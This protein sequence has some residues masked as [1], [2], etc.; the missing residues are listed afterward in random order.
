MTLKPW[1][2]RFKQGGEG[3]G[4]VYHPL[5]RHTPWTAT[6]QVDSSL[7]TP[8]HKH[9]QAGT[10]WPDTDMARHPLASACWDTH[11]LPVHVEIHTPHP[12][13]FG[14]LTPCPVHAEIHTPPTQCMLGYTLMHSTYW[15]MVDK[16]VVCIPLECILVLRLNLYQ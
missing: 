8:L 10:P 2:A 11:P 9:P 6:P 12:V 3:L 1:S 14:I 7:Q 4:G 5:G 13:H 15:D 16:W